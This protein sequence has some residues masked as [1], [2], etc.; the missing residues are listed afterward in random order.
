M[1][2]LEFLINQVRRSTDNTDR[3]GVTDAE[4]IE[5]FNDGIEAIQAIIHS[6]NFKP[7]LFLSRQTYDFNFSTDSYDLP[8]DIY[9]TNAIMMVEV[10]FGSSDVN[11]GFRPVKRITDMESVDFFGYYIRD[12]KIIFALSEQNTIKAFDQF[13]V[14]YFRQ[15]KRFDK[16]WAAV[17]SVTPGTPNTL[18]LSGT[19]TD[20]SNIDDIISIVDSN[21]NVIQSGLQVV[22]YS[23]L[24]ASLTFTGATAGIG[25]GQFV[26]MGGLSSTHTELPES[27][28]PYLL[29]YVRQRIYT[30]QNYGDAGKQITFT[31]ASQQAIVSI[32][33]NKSRDISEPPIIDLDYLG[34]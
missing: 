2:R 20:L 8:S 24:P 25:S 4:I 13:R 27:V 34:Y 7:D 18:S 1:K 29:D 19:D 16:R 22:S 31:Q 23:G 17:T 30:R 33:S 9:S 15:L 11:E 21:G 12:N 26:V 28:K 5:Y 3:N 10:R 6:Q 32:F 14:T